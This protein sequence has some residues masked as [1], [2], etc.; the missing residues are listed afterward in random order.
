VPK[1][2]VMGDTHGEI[3]KM[4]RLVKE[5][6]HRTGL[7]IDGVV[8]LGDLGIY[9]G[10]TDWQGYWDGVYVAPKPTVVIAGN[11]EDISTINRWLSE[12]ARIPNIKLLLDGRI[13]NFLGVRI[14]AI[15]G[16]FS[17]VSYMNPDRVFENR[18]TCQNH[19]IAM[20]I[21]R[22]SVETLLDQTG[23]MDMLIT[24]DSAAIT[25]PAFFRKN[26]MDPVIAE[27][28]GLVPEEINHAAGCPGFNDILKKFKP[29]HYMFGHLHSSENQQVGETECTLLQCIQ[30]N[31]DNNCYK[32]VEF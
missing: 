2:F 18:T 11:H 20:H 13:E 15:W 28:L 19:R 16:N 5:Y 10:T 21:N 30:Y 12:P 14:G 23:P 25:F 17:P 22:Y 3:C 4:Y 1:L 27:I 7:Q 24:H 6:E 32:V 26:R 31:Q 9:P 29:K 8:Q